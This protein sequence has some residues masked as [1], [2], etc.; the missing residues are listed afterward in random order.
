MVVVVVVVVWWCGRHLANG[1][2]D[3][4]ASEAPTTSTIALKEAEK[5]PR[6]RPSDWASCVF[7]LK[8]G[9]EWLEVRD[10]T[11]YLLL[12]FILSPVRGCFLW[13][14]RFDTEMTNWN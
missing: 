1:G 3:A 11:V 13:K 8:T 6:S 12:L 7:S 2:N 10:L 4:M 14:R 9:P 5:V